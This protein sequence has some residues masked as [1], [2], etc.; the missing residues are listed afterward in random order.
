MAQMLQH[1][2]RLSQRLTESRNF[3]KAVVASCGNAIKG[4][5]WYDAPGAAR[6]VGV[7]RT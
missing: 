2:F 5:E 4:G 1:S 6:E 3:G 7:M